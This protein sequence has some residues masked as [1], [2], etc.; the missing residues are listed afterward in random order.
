LENDR[1][2][3]PVILLQKQYQNFFTMSERH[4][5]QLEAQG[6]IVTYAIK[7]GQQEVFHGG[8]GRDSYYLLFGDLRYTINDSREGILNADGAEL[9]P[10]VLGEND[11]LSLF[12]EE[13]SLLCQADSNQVDYMVSWNSLVEA[14]DIDSHEISARLSE[15]NNPS[16]FMQLPFENVEMAFKKMKET[17]V[18]AGDEIIKQGDR[19]EFFYII[20]SGRAEVLQ[21]G[22]YDSGQSQVAVLGVGDHFGDDA[23]IS[24]GARNASVR[25]L[26][27][28]RLWVL[29]KGDYQTLIHSELVKSIS[30]ENA[31]KRGQEGAVF[32]DVRYEEEYYDLHLQDAIQI[33]LPEL[34]LRLKELD[35]R[36]QYIPYCDSSRR[37]SVAAMILSEAGYRAE[38]LKGGVT[39][40]P[41]ELVD[42]MGDETNRG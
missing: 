30:A 22:I 8:S 40:W 14:A 18:Y 25:M 10:L 7:K 19:A 17:D 20:E 1:I 35:L 26:E 24:D 34:R 38:Y 6:A 32:L 9:R 28:G 16:I 13:D 42:E 41:Y 23:L 21:Q 11:I 29:G 33:S 12:A 2:I 39:Q 37:S 31:L 4:L 3:D 27:D 5:L 36:T 15:L